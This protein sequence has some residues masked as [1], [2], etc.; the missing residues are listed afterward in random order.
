[1]TSCCVR[2]LIRHSHRGL[3]AA[4]LLFIVSAEFLIAKADQDTV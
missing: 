1:M 2:R 3:S 4:D